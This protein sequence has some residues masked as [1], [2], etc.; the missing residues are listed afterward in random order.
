[1]KYIYNKSFNL[2]RKRVVKPHIVLVNAPSWS[3]DRPPL[4]IAILYQWLKQ[5]GWK[6]ETVDLNIELYNKLPDKLKPLWS[7][8]NHRHWVDFSS[9]EKLREILHD[10]IEWSVKELLSYKSPVYGFSASAPNR[11]FIMELMHRMRLR[12]R[13][14]FYIVGGRG[15]FHPDE[16]K[17][18]PPNLINRFVIGEGE[19]PL[20]FLLKSFYYS[21]SENGIKGIL[22]PENTS[23]DYNPPNFLVEDLN[24]IPHPKY[25]I[26]PLNKYHN[27]TIPLLFSRSCPNR[28]TF[29]NDHSALGKYRVRDPKNMLKEIK[30]HFE[31]LG[32]KKFGFNDLAING[33]LNALIQLA[34]EIIKSGLKIQWEASAMPKA[35]MTLDV[36]KKLKKSGCHT[37]NFGVES[38]SP[39][40]LKLMNKN[41]T[42]K[43]ME[44]AIKNT[45]LAGIN[46]QLNFIVGFPGETEDDFK[47]TLDFIMRNRKYICGV[48]NVNSCLILLYSDLYYNP[49]KYHITLP[50][51]KALRDT[52]WKAPDNTFEIRQHRLK[53]LINLINQEK[54]AVFV[55]NIDEK[56]IDLN[57]LT[58]SV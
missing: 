7:M 32:I 17:V 57:Q 2:I 37:L 54:L 44:Q 34:D 14:L 41:F 51:N 20:I 19:F 43:E 45:F 42:V 29:C 15:I 12:N 18:F 25:E 46:T 56:E 33:N 55:S 3:I 24:L 40:V 16:R 36:C 11:Y 21:Y 35:G 1:M 52:H 6:V 13:N 26:F 50:Q 22:N 28:C 31:K 47:L 5:N 9:F 49:N 23:I 48:T 30:Y 58:N 38:G 4:N 53:K 8:S 39:K 10:Y 27:L